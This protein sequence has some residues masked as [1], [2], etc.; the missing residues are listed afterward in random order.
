MKNIAAAIGLLLSLTMPAF[1]ET[2]FAPMTFMSLP[3]LSAWT[4]DFDGMLKRHTLRILVPYSKTLFFIDRG[5]QFG[6]EAVLGGQFDDWINAR[7][8]SKT[9]RINVWFVPVPRGELLAALRD[10]RGDIAAGN[11]TI[12]PEGLT[13]VDF[14]EPWRS[15][16]DEIV[17][18]GPATEPIGPLEDLS[19][20]DVFVR[21]SGSVAEHVR[22]LNEAFL[23]KGLR[24]INVKPADGNLEDEDI[25]EMVN[26]GLIPLAI[27][28]DYTATVWSSVFRSLRPRPDL[29]VSAN[30]SMA[31]AIRKGS[32]LLKAELRAFIQQ[33][34]LITTFGDDIRKRYGA[35]GQIAHNAF[36]DADLKRFNDLVE[37][38]KFQARKYRF[39]WRMLM[40]QAYQ[41]SRLDQT[42][43][44]SRGA[45]GVMQVMPATAASKPFG[46]EGVDTDIAMNVEA[47]SAI[48]RYLVDDC[49]GPDPAVDELNRML[50]AFAAYNAGQGSLI[51]FRDVAKRQGL[52]P[53]AWFGNVEIAAG[54]VGGSETI[55]YVDNIYRYYIAYAL[56]EERAAAS[57]A[58]RE[59]PDERVAEKFVRPW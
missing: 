54:Q 27:V 25:L 51:R 30:G 15:K 37:V 13:Q 17:V 47:G 12:T 8:Q 11:L 2:K 4:G 7:H 58:A 55:Q 1:A 44:S 29:V 32:P 23:A 52:N 57:R 35:D 9:Q 20:R 53:N 14:G 43:R 49:V 28:D 22:K 50:F 3:K 48:L 31:W 38:F 33:H 21:T 40:A 18:T 59:R 6:I 10:G 5:Q 46:F 39:D 16:I 42:R 34:P 41:E 36:D 19:G 24:P 45:V 26:A 56:L